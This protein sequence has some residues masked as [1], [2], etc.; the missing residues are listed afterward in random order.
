VRFL[1]QDKN[2]SAAMFLNNNDPQQ[3]VFDYT[4]YYSLYQIFKP[5]IEKA[6]V[7]GGG[8]YS[9]PKALLADFPT[10]QIDVCEVEPSLF[11]LAQKYFRVPVNSHL[12]NYVKDARLF[13]ATTD[14]KYDLIYGDAYLGYYSL[15]I[16]LT[17]KEFFNLVYD[18]LTP[19]GVFIVNF[20]GSLDPAVPSLTFSEIKTFRSVFPSTYFFAVKSLTEKE[21]Q[22]LV[23]VGHKSE[24]KVDINSAEIKSHPD[25]LIAGLPERQ[26]NLDQFDFSGQIELTDNYAPIEYLLAKMLEKH[27]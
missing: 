10:A 19:G 4:K 25:S 15:P 16:N 24:Q 13:L 9:V 12:T 23:F 3:L 8:G 11:A 5:Q 21:T 20:I 18:H 22:N 14:E 26:I 17:T 7:L 27:L 6:L 1:F 2:N